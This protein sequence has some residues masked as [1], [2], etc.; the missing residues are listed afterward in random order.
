MHGVRH[1]LLV[2]QADAA[3][4]PLVAVRIP[5]ACTNDVYEDRLAQA[6]T[7]AAT[8]SVDPCGENGEFHT[9]V[10][11]GP[12]FTEPIACRTGEIVERGGFVFCD[13]TSPG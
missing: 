7:T 4:I 1:E 5:P 3:G 8:P 10:H 11:A 13:L 12:I 9:F 6:W 2:A